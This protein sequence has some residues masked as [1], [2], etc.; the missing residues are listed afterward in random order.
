MSDR[1][2]NFIKVYGSSATADAGGEFILPDNLPDVKRILH[3]M[4][5]VRKTGT[6]SDQSALTCEGE[7]TFGVIYTGDD[8][9][10][11]YTGYTARFSARSPFRETENG[12][13]VIARIGTPDTS[14]RLSNPRKLSLK[15]KITAEFSVYAAENC[16]PYIEGTEDGSIEYDNVGDSSDTVT[17]I[18]ESSVPLSEDLHIPPSQPE[19]EQITA[20]YVMPGLPAAIP[21]DGVINVKF[22]ADVIALYPG[23]DGGADMFHTTVRVSHQ[24]N[25]ETVTPDSVC[26]CDITVYGV[27]YDTAADQ[28]GEMRVIELDLTYDINAV[29]STP[30]K[31]AY[32]ADMYSTEKESEAAYREIKITHALPV[33]SAN[34]TV[35]GDA[36]APLRGSAVYA[37]SE[38]GGARIV[39][40]GGCYC[41]GEIGIYAITY[42]GEY[43]SVTFS[44]PFRVPAN[45]RNAGAEN[46]RVECRTGMPALRAAGDKLHADVE[47]YINVFPHTEKTAEAVSVFKI[48]D[49]PAEK[50]TSPL[51]LYRPGKSE[52]RWQ[53]AKKFKVPLGKLN[54][55][56]P[57]DAKILVIPGV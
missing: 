14:A 33:V 10:L 34:Y 35:G 43:E 18:T 21:G 11:H 55:A 54:D 42:G 23:A 44:F 19:A 29:C 39:C 16:E 46:M 53:T 50:R 17:E 20:L 28:A 8:S 5:N 48:S 12:Y 52:T 24:M 9:K 38:C 15:C 41:E 3:V 31:G 1:Y 57:A 32:I 26:E 25:A 49:A 13:T 2:R 6:F 22:D 27:R 45:C 47:L 30:S 37:T 36:P 4:T 56:N 51:V 7:V 40:D